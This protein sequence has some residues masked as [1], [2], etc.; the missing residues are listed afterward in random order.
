MFLLVGLGNPGKE[1]ENTRH[2][3]GFM[4]VDAILRQHNSPS[5][6]VKFN[7]EINES[8][9]LGHRVLLQ[10]PISYM[11]RSGG[12]VAQAANFLKIPI[13]NIIVFHD[14]LD[15]ASGKVRIKTGGG[16]G[17]HN[18]LRDLD[19]HIGKDYMRVRIGIGHPGDRGEVSDYV[20]HKFSKEEL[21]TIDVI[22]ENMAKNVNILLDGNKD[23]FMTRVT[24][25][26]AAKPRPAQLPQPPQHLKNE[27]H[28][29]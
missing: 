9:I 11:N 7:S 8:I 27:P 22:V 12:P 5:T 19:A 25:E 24:H 14:D 17:G 15:L 10:K 6:K 18:G 2:N 20:L 16:H 23:L 1:Y 13:E 26:F 21:T 3:I 29:A 28:S 4:V